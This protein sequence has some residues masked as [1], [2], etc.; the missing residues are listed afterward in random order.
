MDTKIIFYTYSRRVKY[1]QRGFNK[2]FSRYQAEQKGPSLDE[3][4]TK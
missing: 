1:F 4:F 3:P 2:F